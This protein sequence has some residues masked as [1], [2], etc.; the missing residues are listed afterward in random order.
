MQNINEIQELIKLIA[1]LPGL[2]PKSAKRIVLKLI[3]NRDELVKP[4]ANTLA[5][6]YKNVIRCQSCG[7][8]K[9]NSTGCN[10]C[11]NT[12]DKYNKICVVEDIADQWSIE[13]SNIYRGY[14]HIL[15]GTISSV[16]Q[17]KED[18]L[19]NSLVERVIK[20]NIEEVI[21]ATSA[22]VEGQTTAYYIQDSLKKT[23]VKITKLAQGLPVGGE[24]ESLDDGT[25]YSA[26][27]NR[28]GLKASSD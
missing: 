22:T 6:V 27:K 5:Q 21:L 3:N 17:R 11:E 1:R 8:L 26:F 7:T 15:G 25:L 4:M 23:S 9:S 24:I 14:F 20:E 12:T 28:T 16:G 18:L 13:N 2:G 19:I 10:N